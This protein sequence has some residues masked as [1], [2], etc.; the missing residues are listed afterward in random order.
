MSLMNDEALTLKPLLEAA[1]LAAGRPLE[2]GE[3][4]RLLE[5]GLARPVAREEFEACLNALISE[6]EPRGLSLRRVASGLRIEIRPAYV[7]ALHGLSGPQTGALFPGATRNPGD[8]GLPAT[9]DT[10]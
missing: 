9:R 2:E 3:L 6:Y 10:R 1:L 5:S 8:H 4:I 7:R